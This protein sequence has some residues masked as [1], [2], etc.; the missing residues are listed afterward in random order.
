[1]AISRLSRDVYMRE[2][3][4]IWLDDFF[5]RSLFKLRMPPTSFV[6]NLF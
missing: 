1:M 3:Q 6:V 4:E 5:D 2:N